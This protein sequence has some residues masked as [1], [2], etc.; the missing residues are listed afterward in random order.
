MPSPASRSQSGFTLVELSI[1][2]VVIGLLLGGVIIG[3]DMIR[4]AQL[5]S[6]VT[7]AQAYLAAA[8]LFQD[9]YNCIPGDCMNATTFFSGVTNGN[10]DGNIQDPSLAGGAGERYGIWQH[11]ALAGYIPGNY[12]GRAGPSFPYDAVIGTNVPASRLPITGWDFW[13]GGTQSGN[14]ILYN[15]TYGNVIFAGGRYSN[16]TLIS[17]ILSPAE[18]Y[19]IDL[20]VDNGIPGTGTVRTMYGT[21]APNCSTS[22]SVNTIP[23]ASAYNVTYT[24]IA[25]QLIFITGW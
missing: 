20:K 18:T 7:D 9:K 15:G 25:C 24:G 4:S 1:V 5:R 6:V 2:L 21:S 17:P 14:S 22:G 11:L 3:K 10:G 23:D 16:G 12:T 19:A 8:R 13:Y